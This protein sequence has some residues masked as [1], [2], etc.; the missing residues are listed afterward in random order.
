LGFLVDCTGF[1][2][3][4]GVESILLDPP[5]E[6]RARSIAD[7]SYSDLRSSQVASSHVTDFLKCF[8]LR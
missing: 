3:A 7:K 1:V 4:V 2:N 5:F 8:L 6:A